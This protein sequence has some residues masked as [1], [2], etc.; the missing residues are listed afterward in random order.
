MQLFRLPTSVVVCVADTARNLSD[1]RSPVVTE[2]G[3]DLVFDSQVFPPF[4]GGDDPDLYRSPA[5]RNL[6]DVRGLL[7]GHVAAATLC[8]GEGDQLPRIG[9]GASCGV[10]VLLSFI[11]SESLLS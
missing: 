6:D 7:L 4:R 9:V 5:E 1:L 10:T 11:L 3:L 8:C 2:E